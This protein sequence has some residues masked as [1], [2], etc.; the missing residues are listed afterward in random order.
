MQFDKTETELLDQLRAYELRTRYRARRE[1]RDRPRPSSWR[2]CKKWVPGSTR[3]ILST[4]ACAAKRCGRCKANT[5]SMT[6]LLREV[7]AAKTF[8]ARAAAMHV[9]ADERTILPDALKI[10]SPPAFTMKTRASA[11]KPFAD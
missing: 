3:T 11:W 5:R 8:N 2:R 9:A 4:I 10:C 1:L 7:L 6:N